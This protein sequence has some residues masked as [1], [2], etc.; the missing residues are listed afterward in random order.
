MGE[1]VNELLS[2]FSKLSPL[3]AEITEISGYLWNK[4]WAERNAGNLSAEVTDLFTERELVVG[5]GVRVA[6][7]CTYPDLA[8]RS[9]LVTGTGRRYRDLAKNAAAHMGVLRM[10]DDGCGYELL[11]AGSG[12]PAFRPTSEFPAHLR[13]H[14][15][16]RQSRARQ[17]VVLHTHPTELIVLTHLPRYRNSEAINRA[18][19]SIHP[20]VKVTLPRGL[21]LAPYTVPGT[22]ALA[23]QTVEVFRQGFS[24]ALWQWHGCVAIGENVGEAFDLIDTLNKAAHLILLCRSAGHKPT[25][26]NETQLAELVQT[27]HLPE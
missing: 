23:E 3:L 13:I 22:E 2:A 17:N 26:L 15:F 7:E 5:G 16:L 4:G 8:G 1:Q 9:F 24:V 6:T 11:G 19:W 12:D 21:G 18:L 25:G 14:E 20:E 27:F 10:N